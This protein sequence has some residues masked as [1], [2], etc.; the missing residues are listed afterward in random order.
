M[1]RRIGLL[2]GESTGKTSLAFALSQAL[3]ACLV[4]EALRDFVTERGRTPRQEE[5]LAILTRQ[6]LAMDLIEASCSAS[7]LVCDPAPLMTAVYSEIYFDDFTLYPQAI[8]HTQRFDLLLWCDTDLPWQ[9]EDGMR[10]GEAMR[11]LA[12]GAIARLVAAELA[13][14]PI[15]KVSGGDGQRLS[16][17]IAACTPGRADR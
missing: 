2:G 7:W 4:P 13:D 17:A 10:D 15:A 1:I 11:D 8:A 3:P 16:A 12:D 14:M 5:Q 9:R 6:V